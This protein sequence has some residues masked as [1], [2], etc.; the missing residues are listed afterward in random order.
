MNKIILFAVLFANITMCAFSM[1]LRDDDKAS[2]EGHV[3]DAKTKKPLEY[4]SIGIKATSLGTVSDLQGNFMFRGLKPGKYTLVFTSIGYEKLEEEVL[5]TIEQTAHVHVEMKELKKIMDEVVISANRVETSRKEAPII[6]N[7]LSD[8]AFQQSNAQDISQ[9]LP[10]QSGVRV[11]YNC[12]NCG[13]PQVRINGMEGPYSQILIDS[14]AIM[15]SLGGVYGLEQMPI[16]MVDRIEVVKGGASALFGSNAIAGTINIITKE[17]THPSFSIGTDISSIGMKSFAQNFNSNAVVL[18]KDG[19]AGASFYQTYR[20]RNPYDHDNDGFSEIGKLDAFSFGTKSFFKINNTNKL[21]LEYHTT[22]E[23]RRGGDRFDFQP[24]LANICEMTDHK[25]HSGGLSYDYISLDAKNR[26]SVYASGQYI[27]RDSY[28]GSHQDP[29]AYGKSKDLT[30]LLGT[31]GSNK[32]DKLFFLP[33]S[34]V[35]GLEYNTNNLNDEVKGHNI[36]TKQQTNIFGGFGQ[37]EWNAKKINFLLGGRLDKHN[38]IKNVIFSPRL[39]FMYKSN[40]N[41]QARISYASGYRAPQAYE[42]DFHITQ[43]GGLSL[44]TFLAENLKPEY[45]NSLSVSADYYLQIGENYQAN[46]LLEG[47]YT[48]LKDVF[49]LRV[50]GHDT[51]TNTMIQERYNAKGA[52]V[53]GLSFTGKIS[54]KDRYSFTLGYT[55]QD[56]K[57]KEMEFWS[58]DSDVKGTEEMLRTPNDYGYT[59]LSIKP[60]ESMDISLTGIYTGKMKVPHF[61]GYIVKDKIEATPNFFD[62][63]FTFAYSFTL[64][65]ALGLKLSIGIKNIFNS[66]QNDFDKGINRDAGYIYGPM[67]PRTL[68]F[69]V[70]LFS[71]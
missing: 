50:V 26:Y 60:M 38:L 10:F 56:S 24:H 41:F 62:L 36:I 35:Y 49:A 15:S 6:V 37:V 47:F 57:Y 28:Y 31:Q 69:G 9:A 59:T 52:I 65:K 18:S 19:K 64:S 43:V 45:S 14:R 13:F 55:L 29:D 42:E 32:I 71:I 23:T 61:S 58:E 67:L 5:V 63:N 17:P 33:A 40:D 21:T 8:K 51:L 25:I 44:R 53:K 68:H 70:K 30:L 11:E 46:F 12:Q 2:I 1:P 34:L 4:V 22:Q 48:D 7:V 39:N 54:Y 3:F 16:N 20:K 66:Y 27:D